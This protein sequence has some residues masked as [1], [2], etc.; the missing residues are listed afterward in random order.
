M[1]LS[2]RPH[3]FLCTL[4]FQGKGYSPEF[5]ENYTQIVEALQEN[6]EL[7]I[8]VVVGADSIC[9]ACPHQEKG[10]CT[11]EE[12]IQ[13]LDSHHSQIL[14]IRSGDV[15]TW[16]RGK[17]LLREHMTIEAFHKACEGCQWKSL[18][19]CEDSLRKLHDEA[20]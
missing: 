7:P 9:E 2:F 14:S 19:V 8:E 3:H 1:K 20:L 5:I 6:E 18:G 13:K 17:E 4:G 10:K 15:M 16:K 11:T 12:K